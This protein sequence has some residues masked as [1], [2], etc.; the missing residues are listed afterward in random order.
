MTKTWRRYGKG[1]VVA[2][3]DR[4]T[5]PVLK[6][7][8]LPLVCFSPTSGWL[9]S[10]ALQLHNFFSSSPFCAFLVE[11]FSCFY[12]CSLCHV[13]WS[14]KAQKIIAWM[15]ACFFFPVHTE[16]KNQVIAKILSK[17]FKA[18]HHFLLVQV[19]ITME[20]N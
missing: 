7:S 19:F 2:A 4:L 16:E 12:P 8:L 17:A 6:F 9:K 14:N 3:V 13:T 18:F 5:S 10:S 20:M 15:H 1:G 11:N